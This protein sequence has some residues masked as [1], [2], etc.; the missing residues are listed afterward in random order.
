MLIESGYYSDN[1]ARKQNFVS[2]IDAR[3]KIAFV[4]LA[5]ILNIISPGPSVSICLLIFCVIV[6]LALQVPPRLLL[7]RLSIPFSMVFVLLVTQVFLYGQTPLFQINIA[8][9]VLSGYT[10][11]LMRGI[12]LVL[13]VLAGISLVLLLSMSTSADKLFKAAA[14]FR[15]PGTFVE[16]GL[17]IYRYIFVL[18]EEFFQLQDAQRTRLARNG[19][20]RGMRAASVLGA[21]IILRSYDRAARVFEAMTVRGYVGRPMYGSLDFGLKDALV[22]ALLA[23]VLAGVYIIGRAV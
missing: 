13:R 15:V 23:A 2:G 20:R 17:L 3:T 1:Y 22:A 10:E 16:I 12:A 19:W 6:L 14:W 7:V 18:G 8:G 11:G 21:S 9:W 4:A 5:L